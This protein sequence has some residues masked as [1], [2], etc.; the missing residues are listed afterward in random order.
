MYTG[1][2]TFCREFE[3]GQVFIFVL[4]REAK[5]KLE[6]LIKTD[7]ESRLRFRLRVVGMEYDANQSLK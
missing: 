7:W 3:A 1:W 4:K 2:L 6:E 5:L